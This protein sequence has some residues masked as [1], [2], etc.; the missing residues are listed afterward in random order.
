MFYDM[1]GQGWPGSWCPLPV[2]TSLA[3]AQPPR[4][5]H[6]TLVMWTDT[7]PSGKSSQGKSSLLTGKSF[8]AR[9]IEPEPITGSVGDF[10]RPWLIFMSFINA[11]LN[12]GI[13]SQIPEL[14]N[15]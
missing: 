10:F 13:V 4:G 8:Q 2:T 5:G 12:E 1:G 9:Q 14:I 6:P 15:L 11:Y 3:L 7:L